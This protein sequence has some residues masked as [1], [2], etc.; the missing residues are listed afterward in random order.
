MINDVFK[1]C[2]AKILVNVQREYFSPEI[3][4][5]A[6]IYIH[7][8]ANN[9]ELEISVSKI[10]GGKIEHLYWKGNLSLILENIVLNP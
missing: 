10:R 5:N 3:R 2:I 4:N 6:R 9:T 8:I 1:I 7:N